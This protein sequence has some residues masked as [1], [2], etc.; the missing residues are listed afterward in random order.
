MKEHLLNEISIF[1]LQSV[2][3]Q[4]KYSGAVTFDKSAVDGL[5]R[6]QEVQFH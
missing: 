2:R 5:S 3:S 4:L 1:G 6:L